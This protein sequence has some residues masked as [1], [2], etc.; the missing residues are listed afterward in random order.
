MYVQKKTQHS[1]TDPLGSQVPAIHF[2]SHLYN[3]QLH[4]DSHVIFCK[5]YCIPDYNH[6]HM[7]RI[8]IL[9][10]NNGTNS[11]YK[12]VQEIFAY[13]FYDMYSFLSILRNS[14]ISSC[15][16]WVYSLYDTKQ[17]FKPNNIVSILPSVHFVVYTLNYCT[18]LQLLYF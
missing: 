8:R 13:P 14:R 6:I 17:V 11:I 18:P 4:G 15:I 2:Y 1:N 5:T 12:V 9:K 16:L 7:N 10:N 3:F